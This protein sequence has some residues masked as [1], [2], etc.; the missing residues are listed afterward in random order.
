MEF[1]LF[2]PPCD[3]NLK[4][5]F[6]VCL[7]FLL[8]YAFGGII[9]YFINRLNLSVLQKS[10]LASFLITILECTSG[11]ISKWIYG[12]RSWKYTFWPFC[13]NFVSVGV[14]SCWF[15]ISMIVFQTFLV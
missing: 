15:L 10:L 9:L 2:D 14:S 12:T 3:R 1:L 7:P 11:K 4:W 8:V 13:D 6:G 5:M